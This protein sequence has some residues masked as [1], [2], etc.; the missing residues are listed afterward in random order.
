MGPEQIFILYGNKHLADQIEN[1]IYFSLRKKVLVCKK[2]K[3]LDPPP[4][5][6]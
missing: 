2:K 5:V 4:P 1:V 6:P 3:N